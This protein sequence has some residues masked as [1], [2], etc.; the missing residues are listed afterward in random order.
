MKK[1]TFL[2]LLLIMASIVA[3]GQSRRWKAERHSFV[4][5]VGTN[6]FMG[7]LGGGKKDA[8]HFMGIRDIDFKKTRPTN[9]YAY[10]YRMT[11]VISFRANFT[12][13]FLSGDDKLS[14]AASRKARNLSFRSHVFELSGQFEYYFLKEKE[15]PR[16]SFQSLRSTSNI[17]A[18]IFLGIGG[19]YFN[20]QAKYT[21]DKWYSLRKLGTEG[22]G[23]GVKGYKYVDYATA[24]RDEF[25]MVDSLDFD[26]IDFR[27]KFYSP[28]ALVIPMGIGMKY[29]INRRMAIGLELSNR[30]TSTDY[31]DD[32]SDRYFS[33]YEHNGTE[34]QKYFS[35][36]H[37]GY[38]DN[39]YSYNLMYEGEKE[40]E[41]HQEAYVTG[42]PKRGDSRYT[43]AYVLTLITFH[44]KFIKRSGS[45][46]KY[47]N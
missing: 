29:N 40:G 23:S 10:R 11:E 39:L 31:L 35:D 47:R 36:R 38:E 27:E 32:V 33:Y 18:Y 34:L 5:S 45:L 12:Y 46:P 4:G 28:F 6:N 9:Q 13:A 44:Y 24:R 15:V 43:D 37:I 41:A 20:P 42:K 16:Y 7:E 8:A 1:V 25:G 2:S 3:F 30:Y 19:F 14:G 22:Q 26:A 17:S 21:D